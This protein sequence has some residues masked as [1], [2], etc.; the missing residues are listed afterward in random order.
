[1]TPV[2]YVTGALFTHH[3]SAIRDPG[4]DSWAEKGHVDEL[5]DT[6]GPGECHQVIVFTPAMH[7]NSLARGRAY[8]RT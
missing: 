3:C 8:L 4:V 5:P 1:M 6:L 7:N 2:E